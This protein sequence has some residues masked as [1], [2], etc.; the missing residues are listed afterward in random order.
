[1]TKPKRDRAE[2]EVLRINNMIHL[3][4]ER[5]LAAFVRALRRAEKRKDEAVREAYVRGWN[6]GEAGRGYHPPGELK[7]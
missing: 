5:E 1:M 7:T 3:T 2:R 4:K 6:D